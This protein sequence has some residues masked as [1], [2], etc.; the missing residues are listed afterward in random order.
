MRE[1]IINN[2]ENFIKQ[3][4][5]E[6]EHMLRTGFWL[7][8]IYPEADEAFYI[9]AICHDIERLFPLRDGEVT[10]PK[11]LDDRENEEYLIWHGKRSAEFAEKILRDYGFDDE[12]AMGRIRKIIAG[13]SF[14]GTKEKDIMMDADSISVLENT[15]QSLIKKHKD[16]VALRQKFDSEFSRI[17]NQKAKEL[18]RPFY[19]E[20]IRKLRNI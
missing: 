14:G 18:A 5:Y 6:S 7:K 19:E 4:N 9:A 20:A 1:E 3:K 12:E 13:H 15:A 2:I 16:K 11:S 17:K 8:E 10:P